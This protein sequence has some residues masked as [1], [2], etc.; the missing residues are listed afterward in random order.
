MSP[1]KPQTP[2]RAKGCPNT[3]SRPGFCPEHDRG[4]GPRRRLSHQQGAYGSQWQKIRGKVIR[5]QPI[6]AIQGCSKPMLTCTTSSPSGRW[7]QRPKQ[8][9][10]PVPSAPLSRDAERAQGQGQDCR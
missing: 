4:W 2:C 7:N 1:T 10:R 5:E 6:C 3:V 8:P 9:R